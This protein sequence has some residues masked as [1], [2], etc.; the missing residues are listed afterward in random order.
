MEQA[1]GTNNADRHNH[2]PSLDL[3]RLG[4][5]EVRARIA[6][7]LDTVLI[8]LGCV[9]RH[10]NPH[11]P[12]GL[13]GIIVSAVV[14]RAARTAD[15]VHTP[16]LPF[17]Y[18]PMHVGE[19]ADGC[20]AV[21]LRGE[22]FRRVLEDVGRSL[23]YQGFDRL[24]FVTLHGPNVPAAEEVLWSLR[25]RTGALVACY[26]GRESPSMK[27]IFS[28]SPPERL[29][30]DVEASMA[31]ALLG[32]SFRSSEYLARSYEIHAPEWLGPSFSKVSGMGTAVAFRGAPNVHI[33]LNDFEYTSRI[34]EDMP[35]SQA[36]AEHGDRMLDAL[37]QHLGEFVTEARALPVEVTERDFPERAR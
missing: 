29:T 12:L 32:D 27:E 35:P 33:G 10:G 17:G 5:A 28:A 13:D 18:A 37:A 4:P 6:A 21:T 15:V 14:E 3:S 9:E 30:S 31:M 34:R 2:G 7:G 23:I 25:L 20:G 36:T 26:G 24:V 19:V 22:T 11:T 1:A 16:L 8:P